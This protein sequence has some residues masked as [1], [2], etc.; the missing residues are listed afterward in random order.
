MT[1]NARVTWGGSQSSGWP[2][3]PHSVSLCHA[4]LEIPKVSAPSQPPGKVP[5][6]VSFA[7]PEAHESN[8]QG[9]EFA[10]VLH[11]SQAYNHLQPGASSF[12]A[13]TQQLLNHRAPN[14]S[15]NPSGGPLVVIE[16][17]TEGTWGF[18]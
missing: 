14:G 9:V 7:C 8:G 1:R 12:R 3:S 2:G 11:R 4:R 18:E 6:P 15:N 16:K 17:S 10:T 5:P 13:V